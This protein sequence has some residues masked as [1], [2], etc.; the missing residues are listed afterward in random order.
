MSPPSSR[1]TCGRSR[2]ARGV[3]VAVIDTG[4]AG[5]LPDFEDANGQSRV[6]ASVVTNPYAATPTDTYGH[7]THVAGIIA[8]NSG[9]RASKIRCAAT[10]SASRRRPT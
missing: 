5:A 1:R 3:G 9:H 2:P 8:G 7:G 4:I 10:T 6:I